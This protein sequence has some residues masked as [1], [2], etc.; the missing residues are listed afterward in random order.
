MKRKKI[1]QISYQGT[2][3][4]P[5]TIVGVEDNIRKHRGVQKK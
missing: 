4:C 2:S 3:I 5:P 1:V